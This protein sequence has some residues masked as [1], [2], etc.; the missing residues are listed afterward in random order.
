[1]WTREQRKWENDRVSVLGQRLPHELEAR[2]SPE[3]YRRAFGTDPMR[4]GDR[5]FIRCTGGPCLSRLEM[6]PPRLEIEER[7]GS[8]VLVDDGPLHEW[9]YLFAP[10][11]G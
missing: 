1:M 9:S 8:S 2:H 3:W 11:S 6:F 4:A 10:H 5:L 7:S